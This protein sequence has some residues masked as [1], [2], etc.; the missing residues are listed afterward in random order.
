MRDTTIKVR[1][2]TARF[3]RDSMERRRYLRDGEYEKDRAARLRTKR[4]KFK[5]R[6]SDRI[7]YAGYLTWP[8]T[9][10]AGIPS[11]LLLQKAAADLDESIWRP[12]WWEDSTN[13]QLK[14][15]RPNRLLRMLLLDLTVESALTGLQQNIT[16]QFTRALEFGIPV[17]GYGFRPPVPFWLPPGKLDLSDTLLMQEF[18]RQQLAQVSS[19]GI[20]ASHMVMDE[21]S[22]RWMM[23]GSVYYREALHYLRH[24]TANMAGLLLS[25][26]NDKGVNPFSNYLYF[27]NRE[28][29]QISSYRYGASSLKRDYLLA[30]LTNPYLYNSIVNVFHNYLRFGEDSVRLR[31][32]P[33][34]YAKSL[35]PWIRLNL[36]PFGTEWMPELAVNYHRQAAQLYAR[37]GNNSF[38]ESY[39]GGIKMYNLV[40]NTKVAIHL[41]AAF[42]NQKYFYRNWSGQ[43]V[44]PIGWGWNAGLTSF[45][46]LGKGLNP[47]SLALHAGYKTRGYIEGEPWQEGP[48]IRVGL[49]FAL[50][51]DFEEDDTVPEYEFVS[52]GKGKKKRGIRRNASRR[53]F[54]S[55]NL[56]SGN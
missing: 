35:M 14:R 22:I 45:I 50:E 49:S 23:R 29:G 7:Q 18:S 39:G 34:G 33:L 9:A 6:Y 32:I 19:A 47:L 15:S 53:R 21:L 41:H 38:T 40:R 26:N 25:G 17:D 3:W 1:M 24:Q 46:K 13:Q 55:Q 43:E 12:S 51:N 52:S 11:T 2:D 56:K 42:W 8:Y 37:I 20:E 10:A 54:D 4:R 31:A 27:I 5:I 44:E 36:T 30:N 48:V 16:G 28:F